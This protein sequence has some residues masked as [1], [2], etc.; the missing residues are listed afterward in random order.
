MAAIKVVFRGPIHDVDHGAQWI[1][2][3]YV[4]RDNKYSHGSWMRPFTSTEILESVVSD[5]PWSD[6]II[7]AMIAK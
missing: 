7:N 6:V 3:V 1:M 2:D 4:E 5:V